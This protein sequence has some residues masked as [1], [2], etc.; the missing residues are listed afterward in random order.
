MPEGGSQSRKADGLWKEAMC[1]GGMKANYL[2][3]TERDPNPL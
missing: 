1:T 2:E 3:S